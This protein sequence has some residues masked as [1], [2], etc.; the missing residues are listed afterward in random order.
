MSRMKASKNALNLIKQFEGLHTLRSDGKVQAYL[1]KLV[2]KKYRSP[3]YNGLWTIGYGATGQGIT[4]GTVWTREQA[5]TD[6]K[7]RVDAIAL[8]L[9]DYIKVPLNQNQFDALVSWVY[10]LNFHNLAKSTMLKKLN[11]GDYDGAVATFPRYNRAGGKVYRGLT[12]RRKAEADLFSR[13]TSKVI[14]RE[15]VKNSKKLTF[16]QR[17]RIWLTGIMG[18]GFLSWENLE[19]VRQMLEQ[20]AGPLV[21]AM[22]L[23]MF[24]IVTWLKKETINDFKEDRYVPSGMATQPADDLTEEDDYVNARTA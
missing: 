12:R 14:E 21:L 13:P 16:I 2:A 20:N 3:G 5:E 11:A 18:I 19:Q 4:E 10:N 22:G 7:R 6:L 1:D 9:N 23:A 8:K 17:F 24:L 15:V